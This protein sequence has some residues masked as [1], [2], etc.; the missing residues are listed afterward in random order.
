[1][2]QAGVIPAQL[3]QEDTFPNFVNIASIPKFSEVPNNFAKSAAS[4]MS[5]AFTGFRTYVDDFRGGLARHIEIPPSY[6]VLHRF[7]H[8]DIWSR[9]GRPAV[10]VVPSPIVAPGL[11]GGLVRNSGAA[12]AA[13]S[14]AS[15]AR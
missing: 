12:S 1:M 5:N 15:G 4:A 9:L 13:S 14:A 11:S 10:G 2:I 6:P 8:G 7:V 3:F